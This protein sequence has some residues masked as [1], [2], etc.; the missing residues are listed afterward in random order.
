MIFGP[1]RT[2]R[3]GCIA[4]IIADIVG[5]AIDIIAAIV[6]VAIDIISAIVS[7]A[8]IAAIASIDWVIVTHRLLFR[9]WML[10]I[11]GALT[12]RDL[13]RWCRRCCLKIVTAG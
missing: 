9:G 2:W 7:I 6:V 10:R 3:V 11:P 13:R 8:I 12:R 4:V 1:P 5:I